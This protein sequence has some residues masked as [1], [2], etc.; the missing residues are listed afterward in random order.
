MIEV[1]RTLFSGVLPAQERFSR[2]G[3]VTSFFLIALDDH[4]RCGFFT[5]PTMTRARGVLGAVFLTKRFLG[6]V[7][8]VTWWFRFVR[9]LPGIFEFPLPL[10][11]VCVT[12]LLLSTLF[13]IWHAV[14]FIGTKDNATVA[15]E[16]HHNIPGTILP[17]YS[18]VWTSLRTDGGTVP[19][20]R[21]SSVP[22]ATIDS[23]A[24]GRRDA[25]AH[26]G[27]P[28]Q[29]I[30]RE[31]VRLGCPRPVHPAGDRHCLP[32]GGFAG[33][34]HCTHRP[35]MLAGGAR[36]EPAS[37]RRWTGYHRVSPPAR[38]P[39]VED[40]ARRCVLRCRTTD[41]PDVGR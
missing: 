19:V 22:N 38:D 10:A 39:E 11:V 23:P 41:E 15:P 40:S 14:F 12:C 3:S 37:P 34:E 29:R 6:H 24:D 26:V 31:P 2:N 30:H 18:S 17:S 28:A 5:A 36:H 4:E 8:Y 33:T 13:R 35:R 21:V 7:R 20:R 9:S 27:Y 32:A 16:R 25:R 1:R